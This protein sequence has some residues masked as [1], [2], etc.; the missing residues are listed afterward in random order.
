MVKKGQA[1]R[2]L[3]A[4]LAAWAVGVPALLHTFGGKEVQTAPWVHF[5]VVATGAL[6]AAVAS[7]GL[8]VAGA[9]ASDGRTV[10]LGAA[11]STM[12]ALLM[13]H[14]LATPGN[15]RGPERRDRARGRR[16]TARRRRRARAGRGARHAPP[17]QARPGARDP[18]RARR[19]DPAARRDRPRLPHRRARRARG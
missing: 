17:P 11:F 15:H 2:G 18:G 1:P 16:L 3:L 4:A 6:I 8:T 14:G 5:V 19:R 9:R 7:V 10:L 13:I 12:T